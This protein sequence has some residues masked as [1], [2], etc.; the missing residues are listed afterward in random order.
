MPR[1]SVWVAGKGD[2]GLAYGGRNRGYR[3]ENS[4]KK[5]GKKETYKE[6][7]FQENHHKES[8]KK[9]GRI[10]DSAVIFVRKRETS[11]RKIPQ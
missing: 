1:L 5:N 2:N 10:S 7:R 3:K 9:G 4:E 6:N 11:F 8:S